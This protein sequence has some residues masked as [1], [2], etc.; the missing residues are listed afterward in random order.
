MEKGTRG[1]EVETHPGF[2]PPLSRW[3][4]FPPEFTLPVNLTKLKRVLH[5][6]VRETSRRGS[7]GVPQI[8]KPPKNG[9]FRGLRKG[10]RN[11]L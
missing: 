8:Q 6:E 3:D 7:G 5:K 2:R 10:L 4:G 1:G 11:R 9:G